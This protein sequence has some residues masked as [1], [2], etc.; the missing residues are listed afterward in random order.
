MLVYVKR[1]GC[2]HENTISY[3][4]IR[5]FVCVWMEKGQITPLLNFVFKLYCVS[6]ICHSGEFHSVRV[7]EALSHWV[8]RWTCISMAFK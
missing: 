5:E 1:C 4:F 8:G 3:L 6:F 7:Q 2:A